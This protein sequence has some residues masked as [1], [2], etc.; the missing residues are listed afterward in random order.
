MVKLLLC[1][2]LLV[3]GVVGL[4]IQPQ[5]LNEPANEVVSLISEFT[6]GKQYT[7]KSEIYLKDEALEDLK[8]YFHAG[9]QPMKMRT[10]YDEEVNALLMGDFEGT[11]NEINSGYIKVESNM[12]HY[13]YNA[14]TISIGTFF[15]SREKTYEVENTSPNEYFANLSTLQ[16]EA[17]L[18][19]WSGS[20][21]YTYT[22]ENIQRDENDG[23]YI[24]ALLHDVQYFAAPML[25]ENF[26]AYLLPLKVEVEKVGDNLEIRYF[27]SGA[28]TNKL[29]SEGGLLSKVVIQKGLVIN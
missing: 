18:H 1:S 15:T 29:T 12:E 20:G 21:P 5:K 24:D 25:L 9:Y 11:F 2:S 4:D 17:G 26:G 3:L 6:E 7:K 13:R 23:H 16:L 10:Y 19:T 22:F 28:E 8:D 14:E 27:V